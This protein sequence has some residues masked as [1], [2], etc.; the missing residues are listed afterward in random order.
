MT[1]RPSVAVVGAGFSGLLTALRLLTAPDGPTV[2]LIER[3]GAFAR[4]AA[5]STVDPEHLLNVR[6]ANMSAF[7]EDPGHFV[8][9]LSRSGAPGAQNQF[10][11]RSQYGDYLQA[12]IKDALEASAAGRLLLE[13][14]AAVG[15]ERIGDR[16][17]VKLAMGRTVEADAVVLAIGNLPPDT[18]PG[19]APE[20][21]ASSAYVGDPWSLDAKR[22]PSEGTVLLI[23]TGLSMV[24]VALHLEK[25]RPG[26][27]ML[28]L[29]RRGLLP[30]R[31]LAEGPAPMPRDAP[32][33]PTALSLLRELR[34][35]AERQD[36][37]MV[38]DGL[39]PH[40][41]GIWRGWPAE[42]R[43][44]FLRH[45]RPWWDVHRHRL[46]PPVAEKLDHLMAAG[47]LKVEAGRLLEAREH[48]GGIEVVWTPRGASERRRLSAAAVINCAG[49]NGNLAKAG[50]PLLQAL[51]RSGRIRADAC[52]L[53][54]D[55]DAEGRLIGED[56]L[57]EQTLF[58][59]GPLTRGALWEITSVPDIRI[60]AAACA[61]TIVRLLAA[62]GRTEAVSD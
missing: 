7:A 2:R 15:A 39:R 47:T 10:V 45:A 42:E 37:R 18:L 44:R 24:D 8:H 29:S 50:D 23:G 5:Y 34:R 55:V 54:V 62:R 33:D 21:A 11:R 60:Q 52:R 40:V 20:A 61:D 14:D 9:W 32:S 49:P 38:M 22:L 12:M 19:F 25:R 35:E 53:G 43:R 48:D 27:R 36:W 4:G 41:H 3:R 56:G 58:A 57:I 30:R 51:F 28:A 31:H 13:P 59:V 1:P 26:L 6:A 46:A 17:R 16:W